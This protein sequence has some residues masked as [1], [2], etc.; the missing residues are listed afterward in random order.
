MHPSGHVHLPSPSRGDGYVHPRDELDPLKAANLPD[1]F[2]KKKKKK[3]G[4]RKRVRLLV[5]F[6]DQSMPI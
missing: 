1:L 2:P 3:K 6:T 4:K 5:S